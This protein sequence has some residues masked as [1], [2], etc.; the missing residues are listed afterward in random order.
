MSEGSKAGS[1][2]NILV[3]VWDIWVRLFHWL[4]VSF[5]LLSFLTG[6]IGGFD[7]T[8]PGTERFVSNMNLHTCEQK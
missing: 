5:V 2:G 6:E 7:F 1:G 3:K 8:L 4:L